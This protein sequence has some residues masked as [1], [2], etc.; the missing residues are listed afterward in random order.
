MLEVVE[1]FMAQVVKMEQEAQ[2]VVEQEL[3]VE[4]QHQEQS[5]LVVE[6]VVKMITVETQEQVD[7]ES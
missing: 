4:L 5:T 6:V 1:E 7:Q 2:V 3:L